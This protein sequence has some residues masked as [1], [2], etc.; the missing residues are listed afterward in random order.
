MPVLLDKPLSARQKWALEYLAG[1]PEW[2]AWTSAH[3]YW[4]DGL[5]FIR[6]YGEKFDLYRADAP[7][8]LR[9]SLSRVLNSLRDMG[10]VESRN[11]SNRGS[12]GTND[13]GPSH[14]NDYR[15]T[16]RGRRAAI[17][18]STYETT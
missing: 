8:D 13:H 9:R 7:I 6:A 15:I 1:L 3:E 4:D 12:I 5:N 10:L 18:H 14:C 16:N 11:T 17:S 2:R